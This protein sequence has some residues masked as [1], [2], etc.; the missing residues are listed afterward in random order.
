MYKDSW[1]FFCFDL[2]FT[3]F[4]HYNQT[5]CRRPYKW[6]EKWFKTL[7]GK[8]HTIKL[9]VNIQSL[10]M[11]ST[12][13]YQ[14]HQFWIP[15]QKKI[16][17]IY[18]PITYTRVMTKISFIKLWLRKEYRLTKPLYALCGLAHLHSGNVS[19]ATTRSKLSG[20]KLAMKIFRSSD[21]DQE[22]NWGKEGDGEK[23]PRALS[24]EMDWKN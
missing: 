17:F 18:H 3:T 1:V 8:D 5:F 21:R 9:N 19:Q 23:H 22:D 16:T 2:T 4:R 13:W 14:I 11:Y 7:W 10:K 20:G 12:W 24:F 6:S 15:G